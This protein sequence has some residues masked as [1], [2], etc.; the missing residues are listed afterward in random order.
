[1]IDLVSDL[2]GKPTTPETLT[3]FFNVPV[4]WL[5]SDED[6]CRMILADGVIMEN[7]DWK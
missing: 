5:E 4:N 7:N 1:M 6:F 3:K 2:E